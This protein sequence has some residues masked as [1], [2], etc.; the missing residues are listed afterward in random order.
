[1]ALV[2]TDPRIDFLSEDGV[3]WGLVGESVTEQNTVE[4]IERLFKTAKK[5]GVAVMV[6]PHYY[7][8]T[9]KGW[10]FEGA[11]AKVM[12]DIGMFINFRF[13]A[14]AV[15]TTEEAVKRLQQ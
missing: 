11:L 4:N 7:F 5:T 13:M 14:N 3:T 2:V 9:D 10:K 6:S 8:P 1:M 12:H 15:W